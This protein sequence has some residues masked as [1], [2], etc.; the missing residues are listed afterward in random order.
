[1]WRGMS[2]GGVNHP[3]DDMN[4]PIPEYQQRA[5]ET[6]DVRRARLLYQSR[7]RGMLENGLLLSTFASEYLSK[8]TD[9][10]LEMYDTLINKPTNDWDIYNWITETKPTPKEYNTEVMNM[11]KE[12]AKNSEKVMRNQQP[13][14]YS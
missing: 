3:P 12:H 14:L 8:L 13:A 11:L 6:V 9:V 1:M 5:G 7:K 10:Q 2:S 4:V